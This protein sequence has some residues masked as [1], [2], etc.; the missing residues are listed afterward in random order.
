MNQLWLYLKI[1]GSILKT[2][3]SFKHFNETT[4]IS[5]KTGKIIRYIKE[6]DNG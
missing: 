1:I 5:R 4:V 2:V 3:F 6:E